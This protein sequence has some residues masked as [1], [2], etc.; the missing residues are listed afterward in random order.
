MANDNIKDFSI[1]FVLYGLLFVALCTFA[2]TFIIN[3]NQYAMDNDLLN[4]TNNSLISVQSNLV[5]IETT[6]NDISN[7]TSYTDPE[8]SYLGSKDQVATAYGMAGSSKATFESSKKILGIVLGDN[9]ILIISIIS[10][11]IIFSLV[12]FIIKLLRVGD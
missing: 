6:G 7:T 5:D 10:G 4:S 11:I 2:V 1:N 3:N 8:A 9:A 12:Y